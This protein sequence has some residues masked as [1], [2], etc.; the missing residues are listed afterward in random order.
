[1]QVAVMHIAAGGDQDEEFMQ[2]VGRWYGSFY[3]SCMTM[4]MSITG[5]VDW[6]EAVSPLCRINWLYGPVFALYVLFVV[7]GVLNVLTG[8][9]VERAQEL[10]GLD[11]DL[12]IQGELKRNE[13]FLAEMKVIFEEADADNSNSISWEEFK[14][15]LKNPEVQAYLSTQQLDTY[16]ARQLFNI[17]C[18]EDQE[19]DEVSIDEFIMG[20]MRLKGVAKSVDVVALLEESRKQNRKVK[21]N[22]MGIQDQLLYITKLVGG[23]LPDTPVKTPSLFRRSLTRQVT[24]DLRKGM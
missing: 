9:F 18:G 1:M 14:E 20:C 11:R 15:Y 3:V 17:L 19:S 8:I 5:G 13:A 6:I 16:D 7:V 22:M 12:V 4:T 10:S 2:E 24:G 23:Q 21:E